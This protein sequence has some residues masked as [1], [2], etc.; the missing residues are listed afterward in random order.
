MAFLAV[1]DACAL[2]PFALRDTLLR[3]AELELYDVQWSEL[4]LD[5][6]RT[7][8]LENYGA[9]DEQARSRRAGTGCR[10]RTAATASRA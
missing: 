2:Y 1:V 7:N 10:R 9:S 8:L 6:M 4:I 5:E 3:L